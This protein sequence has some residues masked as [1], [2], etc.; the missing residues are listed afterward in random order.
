MDNKQFTTN[1]VNQNLENTVE[2]YIKEFPNQEQVKMM[3]IWLEKNEKGVY[4]KFPNFYY[5]HSLVC[6]CNADAHLQQQCLL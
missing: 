3:N 1:R 4:D 6:V 2:N 5:K